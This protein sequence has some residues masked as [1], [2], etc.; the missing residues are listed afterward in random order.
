[1]NAVQEAAVSHYLGRA[2][3]KDVA[4]GLV[5]VLYAES[6]LKPG[7]QGTQST[8]T[9]GVLNPSGAYGIASWNG[10]RQAALASFATKKGLDP[11][12][13]NTQLDFVLTE[14]ANSYPKSWAA[15]QN[16][17]T[18]YSQMIDIMVRDYER[19]AN[20]TAEIARAAAIAEDLM[21]QTIPLPAVPPVAPTGDV[22]PVVVSVP[23]VPS[24]GT[25]TSPFTRSQAIALIASLAEW[26]VK[27]PDAA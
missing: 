9:P 10:P 16:P 26:L 20:P 3:T 8:E 27:N 18:T 23:V 14:M 25:G 11:A 12:Q 5:S 17:E 22:P 19:P 21:K 2:L 4:V 24:P 13:L 15:V 6:A 1:M 7:S